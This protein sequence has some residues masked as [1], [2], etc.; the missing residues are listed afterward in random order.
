VVQC[1]WVDSR[2]GTDGCEKSRSHRSA[3]QQV[4]IPTALFRPNFYIISCAILKLPDRQ[5]GRLWGNETFYIIDG[6]TIL[7]YTPFAVTVMYEVLCSTSCICVVLC[8][9]KPCVGQTPRLRCPAN[10]S[11]SWK[12]DYLKSLWSA[13][14]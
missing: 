1:Q 9:L 3:L 8:G 13:A 2:A 7:S 4:A 12:R 6:S 5:Y 11:D 10:K 14:P